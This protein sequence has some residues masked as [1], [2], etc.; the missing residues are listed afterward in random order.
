[1]HL[2]LR[3]GSFEAKGNKLSGYASVYDEPSKPLV[4][5]G[6]NDGRPFV[7]R[8][9]RGAF[10]A[11]LGENIHMLVGHDR[12]ELL[13]TTS[14]GLLKLASNQRGLHF[15]VDLPDTQRSRDVRTLVEAGV[16]RSMSFGFFVRKDSWNGS[17]RT[18]NAVDLREISVVADPAYP[19]TTVEAR[20][21]KPNHRLL[22]RLR[23]L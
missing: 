9:A 1:M 2:E 13:A 14:S 19:Q 3:Q 23:S 11:S 16:M 6:V 20:T 12:R 21:H 7:E 18:L 22:L 8:V 5:R 15:E 17:E 10:D 4:I